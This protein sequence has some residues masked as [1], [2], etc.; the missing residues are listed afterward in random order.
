MLLRI[1]KQTIKYALSWLY[2]SNLL[3]PLGA[4]K[5]PILCYHSV[6]DKKNTESKP[7]SLKDFEDHLAYL[8]HKYQV[9]PLR[10]LVY[11][12][13]SDK[14]APNNIVAITFD[15]G[16]RDNY[17]LAL[18][19]L[20]K[21]KCHATFFLVSG[22]ID[23]KVDLNGQAGFEAMSWEQAKVPSHSPYAEIGAHSETHEI[24]STLSEKELIQEIRGSKT[25]LEN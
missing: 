3:R 20:E 13:L 23:G 25:R 10:E 18:P 21:Y 22:F 2:P 8:S 12:L 9:V 19:L 7:L 1:N 11:I 17:E 16:Y 6:N 4:K 5:L 15:D 14:P 24:L